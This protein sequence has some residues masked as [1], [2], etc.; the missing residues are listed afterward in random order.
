MRY[1]WKLLRWTVALLAV[2]ALGHLLLV[3][4][5]ARRD[6]ARAEAQVAD[7]IAK[8]WTSVTLQNV[9]ALRPTIPT[10]TTCPLW[11]A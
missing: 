8:G 6:Y 4:G 11:L 2:V 1:L 10:F 5:A 3:W 9:P 7:A